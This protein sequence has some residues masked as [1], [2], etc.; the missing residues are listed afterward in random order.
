MPRADGRGIR[1]RRLAPGRPPAAA[2]AIAPQTGEKVLPGLLFSLL[3][4]ERVTRGGGQGGERGG[5]PG[6]NAGAERVNARGRSGGGFGLQFRGILCRG[7][8]A[9]ARSFVTSS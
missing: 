9:A 2:D 3:C 8:A 6:A 1:P 5:L 7:F 4:R